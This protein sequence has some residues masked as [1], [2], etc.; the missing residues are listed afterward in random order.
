MV[1]GEP[2]DLPAA[3][4]V[5]DLVTELGLSERRI[6]I[7]VNGDVVSRERYAAQHLQ[8]DDAIE[9]VHFIGGG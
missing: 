6:A 3:M 5:A 4:T 2:R 1:N 7:E 9:V 8:E